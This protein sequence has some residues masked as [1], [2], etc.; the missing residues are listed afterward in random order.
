MAENTIETKVILDSS[1]AQ[2]SIIKLN[3]I[4]SDSTRTAEERYEAKNKQV[5]I[6]NDLSKKTISQIEGEIKAL[7]G[8]EGSEKDIIKL[9]NKRQKEVDKLTRA[10][11]N[12]EKAQRRLAKALADSKSSFKGLDDATGGLLSK[13]KAFV[14]NPIGLTITALVGIFQTFKEVIAR[15]GEASEKFNKITSKLSGI[16]NA[17][18]KTLEPL[19]NFLL[20]KVLEAF[21]DPQKAIEDLATA[22]KDNLI[23]RFNSLLDTL[24]YV[25]SAAKKFLTG[26]F[27]GALDDV[28]SA[29]KEL[30]D[31]TTG[32]NNS[33]DKMIE[34]SEEFVK[35]AKEQI[36]VSDKLANKERELVKNRIEL[37]KQQLRSQDL[38]EKERQIRDDISKTIPERIEANK[39]LGKIL[40]EQSAREL[41]IAQN[42]LDIANLEIKS[43]GESIENIEAKGDAELK[44]IEIQE[45]ITS[46]RSEQLTNEQALLKEQRDKD[47]EARDFSIEADEIELERK[48]LKNEA[49]LADEL[50]FLEKQKQQKLD[51]ERI[52]QEEID[53]IDSE[54][55]LLREEKELENSELLKEKEEEVKQKLLDERASEFAALGNDETAKLALKIKFL[56]QDRDAQI[57]FAKDNGKDT[58]KINK[59]FAADETKLKKELAASGVKSAAKA[60]GEVFGITKELALVEASIGLGK[61]IGAA[62]E[63]NANLGFPY[64]VA[65]T[66][67]QI[68]G[69][70]PP[71]I[72]S[73]K[74]IKSARAP[75][76]ADA[77]SGGGGGGGG[78]PSVSTAPPPKPDL[79]NILGQQTLVGDIS[80]NNQARRG[81][82]P[83]ISSNATRDA[84][85]SVGGGSSG[86]VIFSEDKYSDFKEEVNFKEDKSTI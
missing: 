63:S 8:L 75:K 5:K 18:L 20:D 86:N 6:Q 79:S 40:D 60:A 47:K 59:K 10:N 74:S 24:G 70:V 11:A 22:I 72:S 3:A 73:I 65:A 39:R 14:T 35:T 15:N 61:S 67:A 57:K 42:N 81:I 1:Q 44:L 7:E 12:G 34:V 46:Q 29:G 36:D 85:S 48:R 53:L 50:A 76:G 9:K 49:T 84:A 38:A 56:K 54:F 68:A 21:N 16:F 69:Q 77:P 33:V 27:G 32:V 83:S 23:E 2:E 26:D 52:T 41:K 43:T 30:I 28:K 66:A 62:W 71:I 37:E 17:L 58:D 31:V 80:A 55:K 82:D 64:N 19:V 4:A 25:A 51:K 13:M 45:R 78:T